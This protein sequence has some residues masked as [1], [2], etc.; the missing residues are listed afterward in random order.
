MQTAMDASVAKA[1]LRDFLSS[2]V[3]PCVPPSAAKAA[4]VQRTLAEVWKGAATSDVLARSRGDDLC[5]YQEE[6]R[7]ACASRKGSRE[8]CSFAVDRRF[9]TQLVAFS[10]AAAR[11]YVS[12]GL[13]TLL[14]HLRE[15]LQMPASAILQRRVDQV[16]I[17]GWSPR[18]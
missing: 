10:P 7:C 13:D 18:N 8:G 11:F 3:Q 1:V 14:G 4:K 17:Y 6:R 15:V 12:H 16:V 5:R 2:L 9:E